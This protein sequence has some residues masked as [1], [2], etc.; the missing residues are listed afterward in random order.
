MLM[1]YPLTESE[2]QEFYM[3]SSGVSQERPTDVGALLLLGLAAFAL[4]YF[5]GSSDKGS[6]K[7]T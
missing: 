1:G 3:L 6:K 2:A 7:S 4:G 5:I